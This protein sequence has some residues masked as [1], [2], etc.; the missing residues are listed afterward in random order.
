M[1]PLDLNVR[2]RQDSIYDERFDELVASNVETRPK[3]RYS[4]DVIPSTILDV[5]DSS[6]IDSKTNPYDVKLMI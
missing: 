4:Y 3:Q 5:Q 1:P 2:A 6:T